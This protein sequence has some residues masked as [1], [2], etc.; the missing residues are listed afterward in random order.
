[1]KVVTISCNTG[2]MYSSSTK[3]INVVSMGAEGNK[4]E[5]PNS[6]DDVANAT[7]FQGREGSLSKSLLEKSN[8]MIVGS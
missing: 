2:I 8:T 6:D 1:M 7:N 5:E 3:P 4:N